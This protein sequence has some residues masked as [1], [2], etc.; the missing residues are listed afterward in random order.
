MR[1]AVAVLAALAISAS[2]SP[3]VAAAPTQDPTPGPYGIPLGQPI[4]EDSWCRTL[5]PNRKGDAAE[6]DSIMVDDVID[7]GQYGYYDLAQ[8]PK[9]RRQSTADSSGNDHVNGLHWAVPLL[10]TGAKRGDAAMVQRFFDLIDDWLSK[11]R[12]KKKRTWAVTQPI[13]AGERLWALTCAADISGRIS[14]RKQTRKEAIRQIKA[15]QIRNGTN[16]TGIHSQGSALAAFCYLGDT[17]RRDRAADNLDRLA[18]Y[19]V[20]PDGSDREGSPWYAY[21]SLRLLANLNSV[22]TRCGLPYDRIA[23]AIDR[24]SR[25]L[26]AAVDPVFGLVMSGD[27]HR[28]TLSP[29][30]FPEGSPAH[31]A[32]T[33]GAAGVPPEQLYRVFA[34][35][36]V[37]GR[38]AWRSTS[39]A[40]ASFYSVR[41]ARPFVTA[42]VHSD[43][44][45]VT[46]H[47]QGQEWIGDPGPYRYDGSALRNYVVSR[48]G[49]SL[50]RITEKPRPKPAKK[51]RK[52]ARASVAS[53]RATLRRS[54]LDIAKAGSPD[55]TCTKDSTYVAARIY[56][57]VYFDAGAEALVVEDRIR[58]RKRL[59]ADQR[60]QIPPGVTARAS[61]Q[62]ATLIGK[63]S[64]ATMLFDGG[65]KVRTLRPTSSRPD[66]WF[67]Q[68]YGELAKGSVV[69]RSAL[70]PK[71][72]ERTWITVIAA[73]E[74]PPN[75][76]LDERRVQVERDTTR[77]LILP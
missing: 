45:S 35:G 33:G 42:H 25:F 37:F 53:V 50:M 31:W 39:S 41:A 20:L 27:T 11:H 66:G 19:L 40:P 18:D 73:G 14:L 30:W 22:Y 47:S 26:A 12:K 52:S 71:G 29:K 65:G 46:F 6:A 8:R 57:C 17:A 61:N 51:T 43:L 3:A 63:A 67:T 5:L 44:G 10:Y 24:T 9:W 59:R 32:A 4:R 34:G 2:V 7:L 58:A 1:T 76:S 56:R 70:L 38:S 75:L 49:H 13:I 64:S 68:A 74:E 62:S 28:S 16:N 55:I 60:W 77:Q 69:Q 72:A 36:Y 21:Y 54:G 48:S 23:D 15:F